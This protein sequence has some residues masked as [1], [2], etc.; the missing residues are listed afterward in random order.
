MAKR[1][2]KGPVVFLFPK[3]GLEATFGG[4]HLRA[5]VERSSL[6]L[7]MAKDRSEDLSF[8]VSCHAVSLGVQP[9]AEKSKTDLIFCKA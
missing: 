4:P 8:F 7:R 3:V 1:Q 5:N 6:L 2:V 9:W